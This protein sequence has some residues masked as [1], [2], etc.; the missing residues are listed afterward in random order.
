[1]KQTSAKA[2]S[3][4]LAKFPTSGNNGQKWGTPSHFLDRSDVSRL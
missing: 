3:I 1:M 4:A 2:V